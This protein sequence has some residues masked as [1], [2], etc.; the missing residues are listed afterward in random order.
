MD[1]RK[2]ESLLKAHEGYRRLIYK[3]SQGFWTGGYGRNLQTKGLSPEEALYLLQNDIK[4]CIGLLTPFVWFESLDD[5]RK[6]VM[7]ELTFN[8][9]LPGLLKFK[10]TLVHVANH[11][12]AKA[13]KELCN[14]QW[15]RQVSAE[16]RDNICYRLEHGEYL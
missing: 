15:A 3:C 10:K 1:T 5:V 12:W 16:R 6:G 2:L 7:V 4:E 14:S 8:M 9:G 13:V 11:D